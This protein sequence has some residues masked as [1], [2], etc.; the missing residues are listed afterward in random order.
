M[1][2]I[3]ANNFVSG[4]SHVFHSFLTEP[5][6]MVTGTR[7]ILQIKK[8]SHL[9]LWFNICHLVIRNAEKTELSL[10]AEVILLP[11]DHD[12]CVWV[13]ESEEGKEEFLA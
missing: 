11:K 2:R 9:G 10:E 13:R 12:I 4:T 6:K 3:A 8:L 1:A 5:Y 7:P